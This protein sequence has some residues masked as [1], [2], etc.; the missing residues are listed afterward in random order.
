MIAVTGANGLLGRIVIDTL[1]NQGLNV[2]GIV[3]QV[4]VLPGFR[5]GDL[6]DPDSLT[7]ALRGFDIVVHAA[8]LISFYAARNKELFRT[9]I[10][11]TSHLVNAA[12]RAGVSKIIFI[13]S[14]AALPYSAESVTLSESNTGSESVTPFSSYYGYTKF[15]A[16]LEVYRGGEEGLAVAI[17]NPSVVLA[18]TPARQS[19]ARIF[20]Y[21][22]R[23]NFFYPDAT[24]HFVDARD[25]ALAVYQM[26]Q[27]FPTGERFI[28]H[29]GSIAY[30]DFFRMVAEELNK[31]P[32][33]LRV[34]YPLLW[35]A[36]AGGETCASLLSREPAITRVMVSSLQRKVRYDATKSVEKLGITYRQIQDTVRWCCAFY[37][38][39]IKRND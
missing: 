32:P 23:G 8:G 4:P 27:N 26:T 21:V 36:A 25:V 13:S 24:L 18:T 14:V 33:T 31:R 22:F 38:E 19:S 10:E 5:Y 37:R 6:H 34:P 15:R 11:G 16:E 28:I 29:G 20:E 3:R 39:N 2:T 30:I 1:R 7:D 35:M 9:N 12:L 17:I